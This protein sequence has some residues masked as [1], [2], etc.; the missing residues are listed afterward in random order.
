MSHQPAEFQRSDES[1]PAADLTGYL[2]ILLTGQTLS[3]QQTSDVFEAM[4]SGRCHHGEMGAF[5]A[6][7]AMRVPTSDELLGAAVVMRKHVDRIDVACNPADLLDT[8]GTGGAPKTFNVSTVAAI[9]AA[10]GGAKVVKHGNRS[11]TGRGSSEVLQALGVDVDADRETQKRCLEE[12]GMCFAF[13]IHHH[14]ATKHVMPVRLALGVPTIFNLLGPLT[15]PAGAGRQVMGVYDQRFLQ[16]IA[17]ALSSLGTVRSMVVHSEDGLDELS[18]S[19]PTMV[20]HTS[21]E[22]IVEERVYREALG[23]SLAPR[24][25]VTATSLAEAA[26]MVTAILSGEE[27]GPPLEMT[28]LSVA[29]CLI[30]TDRVQEWGDGIECAR[31]LISSGAAMETLHK[32][33]SISVG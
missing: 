29:A 28:L 3:A 2:K 16:P 17:R 18:I 25:A 26:S 9:I 22:G 6:L 7:V 33:K 19:A 20:L 21:A 31:E 32:L 12:A 14:P 4:M 23:L 13:A 10:S 27:S 11:R 8:A 30:V 1:A 5:L 15:N 24:E